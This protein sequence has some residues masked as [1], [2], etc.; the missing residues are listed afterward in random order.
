VVVVVLVE[1]MK[2]TLALEVRV[3]QFALVQNL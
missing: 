3:E 1:Q 2:S